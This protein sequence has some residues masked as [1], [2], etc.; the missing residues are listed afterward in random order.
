[1]SIIKNIT[2]K[3]MFWSLDKLFSN[4]MYGGQSGKFVFCYWGLKGLHLPPQLVRPLILL[5]QSDIFT[6]KFRTPWTA[7]NNSQQ[8]VL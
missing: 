7:P 2:I 1:M 3:E 8:H 6:V 4:K 5:S